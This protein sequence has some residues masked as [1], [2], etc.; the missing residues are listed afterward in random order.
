MNISEPEYAM[1]S[2]AEKIRLARTIHGKTC[3]RIYRIWCRMKNRCNNKNATQWKWYG[4]IGIKVCE[5]W[6]ES[7]EAFF[8]DMGDC[9]SNNHS[10]ERMDNTKGYEPDN[11]RWATTKE[12]ANNR[13][14]N[15]VISCKGKTQTLQQWAEE[16]GISHSTIL[17]RLKAGWSIERALSTTKQIKSHLAKR[18]EA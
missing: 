8:E 18:L 12:Q 3:T 7:F 11:C 14:S 4:G 2:K 6:N 9:P 1:L 16:L 17:M 5:R 13:R 15:N 10:I